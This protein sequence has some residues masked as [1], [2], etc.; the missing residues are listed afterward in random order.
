VCRAAWTL[1]GIESVAKTFLQRF[2]E[3]YA[4]LHTV[5]SVMLLIVRGHLY[6]ESVLA[7]LLRGNL[8]H[9]DELSID[10]FEF[11]SKVNLCCAMGLIDLSLKPGLTQLGK[12]RNKYVHQLDYEATE[13]DQADLVNALKSTIGMP[14]QYY[15]RRRTEFPNGFRRSV[16][17]LWL[18]LE[19]HCAP[20]G[21]GKAMVEQINQLMAT[22][23]GQSDE[24][25]KRACRT[26]AEKFFAARGE[27][28]PSNLWLDTDSRQEP[29]AG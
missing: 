16:I 8:K 3:C 15:L 24:E 29:R 19:M 5:E 26:E 13:E 7:E 28:M 25:F 4:E 23:S 21:E 14:A 9:P 10:R 27:K 18:P 6:C 17:A 1:E 11:Q 12:L 20:K 22:V 2:A